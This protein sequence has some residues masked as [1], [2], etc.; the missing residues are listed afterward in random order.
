M[1]LSLTRLS[2]GVMIFVLA[3]FERSEH[4]EQSSDE[5]LSRTP[6]ALNIEGIMGLAWLL[7]HEKHNL[8]RAS[9]R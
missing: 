3:N 6:S 1:M 7:K 5:R 4:C 2:I 8:R 9:H